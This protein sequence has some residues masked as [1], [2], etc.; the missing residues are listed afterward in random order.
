MPVQPWRISAHHIGRN[1][2]LPC[3]HSTHGS[4]RLV[5]CVPPH[6][7]ALAPR[8]ACRSLTPTASFT[9]VR[10]DEHVFPMD[11][12]RPGSRPGAPESP[13]GLGLA[14]DRLLDLR[15]VGSV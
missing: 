13:A 14:T 4:S 1:S 10:Q 3:K 2:C 8:M 15:P 5:V 9:K 12:T 11:R 7:G 6:K